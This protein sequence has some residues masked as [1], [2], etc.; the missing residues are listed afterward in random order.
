M[1]MIEVVSGN[2]KRVQITQHCVEERVLWLL[3]C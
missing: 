1:D 3:L 2:G